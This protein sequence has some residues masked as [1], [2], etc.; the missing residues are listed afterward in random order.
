MADRHPHDPRSDDAALDALFQAARRAPLPQAADRLAIGFGPR[1]EARM[2]ALAEA[3]DA[4]Q[5]LRRW[6]TGLGLCSAMALAVAGTLGRARSSAPATGELVSESSLQSA[7]DGLTALPQ[8]WP[9]M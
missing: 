5:F 7:W 3:S 2:R 6:L 4:A 1:M 8:A 9:E